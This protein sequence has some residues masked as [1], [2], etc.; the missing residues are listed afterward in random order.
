MLNTEILKN[1]PASIVC[2]Q[3]YKKLKVEFSILRRFVIRAHFYK[4]VHLALIPMS[5]CTG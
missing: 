3:D 5:N 4:T 2:V 1:A